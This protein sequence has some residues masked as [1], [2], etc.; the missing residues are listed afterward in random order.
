MGVRGPRTAAELAVVPE[1]R[2]EP[3]PAPEDM[4]DAQRDVWLLIARSVSREHFRPS[5]IPLLR[6][7]CEAT[8]LCDRAAAELAA[9]AHS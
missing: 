1:A 4:G 5:D 9:A 6:S 2:V 8:V 7:F 3:L